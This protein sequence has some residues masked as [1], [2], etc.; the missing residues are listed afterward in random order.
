MG[1]PEPP[2]SRLRCQDRYYHGTVDR[3]AANDAGAWCRLT[4]LAAAI[5]RLNSV[6]EYSEFHRTLQR[7]EFKYQPQGSLDRSRRR[8]YIEPDPFQDV[9]LERGH[10]VG[11]GKAWEYV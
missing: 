1:N 11:R 8:R 3:L 6:L 5:S 10:P 7:L 2:N 9:P 4:R